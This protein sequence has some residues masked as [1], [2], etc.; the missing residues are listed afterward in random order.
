MLEELPRRL[1]VALD[2]AAE[3][4]HGR[5]EGLEIVSA[6]TVA[7]RTRSPTSATSPK[8][9]PGPR[10]ARSCPSAETRAVPSVMTKNPIPRSSPCLTTTVPAGK[11]RSVK[12]RANRLSSF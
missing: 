7:V 8:W 12:E 5:D 11:S 6:V 4:P 10:T 3:L 1:G 9:S 2:E